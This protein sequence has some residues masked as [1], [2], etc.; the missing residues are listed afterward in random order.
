MAEVS[1]GRGD[2]WEQIT[3]TALLGKTETQEAECEHECVSTSN[4]TAH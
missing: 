3:P 2:S 1:G 4:E